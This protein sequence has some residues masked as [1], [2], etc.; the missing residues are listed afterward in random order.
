MVGWLG[1]A[2]GGL[3]DLI[4]PT[5]CAGCRARGDR[6]ICAM[7]RARLD[8]SRPHATTP[9]PAPPGMPACWALGGYEPPLRDLLLEYKE[10]G[11]HTLATPLGDHLARVVATV[12]PGRAVLLVPVPATAA[13]RRERFGD[14][15]LR[16]AR[17]AA[18]RLGTAGQ[19]A[20][21]ATV[22]RALPR[23][24]STTLDAAGRVRA[25]RDA[26]E[27]PPG[28]ASRLR[29]AVA[30]GA[31]VVVVDDIVTTGATLAA[32]AVLL[33]THRVPVTGAAV[34]AATRRTGTRPVAAPRSDRS[35]PA[36]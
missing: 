11:R 8:A 30:R 2:V 29:G 16:L 3:A 26:F 36:V 12:A 25:A 23:Q 9:T 14:H 10:R 22:L 21:V 31:A 19:P 1:E 6:Q 7:C 18:R 32:V 27:V 28:P 34:L 4:L 24:D 15:M 20:A 17:R 13:A 35:Q 33:A 5:P